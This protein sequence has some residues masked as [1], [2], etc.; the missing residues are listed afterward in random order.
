MSINA[1]EAGTYE[2]SHGEE[3]TTVECDR[4]EY[5]GEHDTELVAIKDGNT[6][7]VFRWWDSIT[8]KGD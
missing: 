7:A 3:S 8:R 1:F 2:I 6:V 5:R 4:L